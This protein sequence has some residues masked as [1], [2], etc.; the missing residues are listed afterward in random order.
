MSIDPGTA[1]ARNLR[2]GVTGHRHDQLA[3]ADIPA[4]RSR[5]YRSLLTLRDLSPV[6]IE[7]VTSLA[8]GADR[9]AAEEALRLGYRLTCL[10]PFAREIY[11]SD[12]ADETSLA[13][14]RRLLL[15]ATTIEELPGSRITAGSDQIAYSAAGQRVIE[16][17]DV[18]LA[19]WNGEKARGTGGTAEVIAAANSRGI[20]TIWIPTNVRDEIRIV[21]LDSQRSGDLPIAI[22]RAIG[23]TCPGNKRS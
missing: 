2:V 23:P 21:A 3:G 4:I 12:F 17:A 22:E 20:P 8:E 19:V 15:Q 14:F 5:V 10:L 6:R 16:L 1:S 7:L 13:E 11:E 18:I 9:I